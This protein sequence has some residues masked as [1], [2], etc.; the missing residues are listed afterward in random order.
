MAGG[1]DPAMLQAAIAAAEAE[2][3]ARVEA[4]RVSKACLD[5]ARTGLG[6]DTTDQGDAALFCEQAGC[7]SWHRREPDGME[8]P[9]R[10]RHQSRA[11][12]RS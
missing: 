7:S 11:L 10:R 8:D 6:Q 2:P 4:E 1:T 12:P 5:G 3:N 9:H